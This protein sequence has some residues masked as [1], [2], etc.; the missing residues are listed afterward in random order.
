[1]TAQN[2]DALTITRIFDAPREIVWK[3]WTD[4]ETFKKWWGP[5]DYTSTVCNIDLRV[6]GYYHSNIVAPDG[7]VLIWSRGTYLEL[8]PNEHI[9]CT[10]SFS[11]EEGNIVPASDYGMSGEWSQELKIILDFED[12]ESGKTKMT[13]NHIGLPEGEMKEMC[14]DGWQQSFDKLDNLLKGM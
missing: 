3:A 13:L 5:K 2:I 12:V 14:K 6:N 11:D 1:M 9:V 7:Q 10:D 4:A 8:I